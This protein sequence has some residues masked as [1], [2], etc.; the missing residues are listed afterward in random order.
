MR[1]VRGVRGV[2]GEGRRG[3][4]HFAR[5]GVGTGREGAKQL[6]LSLPVPPLPRCATRAR[7]LCEKYFFGG[8]CDMGRNPQNPN[9]IGVLGGFWG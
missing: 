9:K 3:R 7:K 6:P 1:G 8:W 5:A 2:R 4:P